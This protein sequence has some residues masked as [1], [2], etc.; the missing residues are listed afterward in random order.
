MW[1]EESTV[2]HAD[3][4]GAKPVAEEVASTLGPIL[5]ERVGGPV[6]TAEGLTFV[7]Q[8]RAEPHPERPHETEGR[9]TILTCGDVERNPGP[10]YE[11][12]VTSGMVVD[13]E[14]QWDPRAE[15]VQE[16][17]RRFLQPRGGASALDSEGEFLESVHHEAFVRFFSSDCRARHPSTPAALATGPLNVNGCQIV[18]STAAGPSASH[19][20]KNTSPGLRRST[21]TTSFRHGSPARRAKSTSPSWS[22][23][24]RRMIL[25]NLQ[26]TAWSPQTADGMTPHHPPPA[27]PLTTTLA[28]PEN[29]RWAPMPWLPRTATK[30]TM[31]LRAVAADMR[32]SLGPARSPNPGASPPVSPTPSRPTIVVT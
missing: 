12:R 29:V 13:A 22:A 5:G 7:L 28:A 25:L 16:D 8:E 15:V 31:P 11:G 20:G 32:T 27:A 14:G 4:T 30:P 9:C 18:T 10:V 1:D 6:P 2:T 21:P 26:Q 17:I 3:S 24:C 19:R 23:M